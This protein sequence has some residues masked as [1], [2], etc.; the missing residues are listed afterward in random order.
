MSEECNWLHMQLES[1]PLIAF[2]FD[3]ECL[4]TNAVYFI[5]ED[6]EKC[7]HGGDKA[8]IVRVGTHKDSNFQSRIA[9]HFLLNRPDEIHIGPNQAA[10]KDRSIFRK[11][12]GRALLNRTNDEYLPIWEIDFTQRANREQ[13]GHIRDTAKEEKIETEVTGELREHFSFRFIILESQIERMGTGG[14]EGRLIGTVA[15]C[16][17]CGPSKMWLGCSSPKG[18]IRDSG[19]WLVQHLNSPVITNTDRQTISSAIDATLKWLDD[20][21]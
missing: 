11:N 4:P 1:L 14:L 17:G 6:G 5:Y 13:Y 15:K 10:P 19:L 7:G 2:P 3:P 21:Q 9:E 8:R 20:D 16:T 12:I 18:K